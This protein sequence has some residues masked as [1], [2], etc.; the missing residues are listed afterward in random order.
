MSATRIACI[1]LRSGWGNLA[2]M[3]GIRFFR[4]AEA[5]ARRGYEVD[6][7]VDRKHDRITQPKL[8]GP[9]LREVPF[10][11]VRWDDYDV[12]KTFFHA[13]FE[14]L[15]A[16][17]GGDHPFIVS[18]LGSVVGHE[19]TEG[20]YFFGSRRE[21]LF[22]TQ[23][24]IAKRSRVVTVLTNRSAALWW[25]EHGYRTRVWQVPTGVD[26]E[27][28]RIGQNPYLAMGISEPVAIYAGNIYNAADQPEVN[29]L[30]QNRLNRIG[31]LLR[32]D[33]IRLVVVGAG[34][35]DQLDHDVVRHVGPVEG[36]KFWDWQRYARVGLVLAQGP[37]QDNESSKIYYYLRTGLQVVCERPVPNAWL[38]ETTAMGAIVDYDDVEGLAESAARLASSPPRVEG[39]GESMVLHHSWDVRARLYDAL[40]AEARTL[41]NSR[42]RPNQEP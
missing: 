21:R 5:L 19:E 27:I 25:K 2:S 40:F 36:A 33:G 10:Q 26:A 34:D 15:L 22:D 18:K 32:R 1:Y 30:W 8:F 29:R 14:S 12:V 17:G 35:S 11:C 13:G 37:V 16:M 20:V 28:P 4:M 38:L 24:E 23:R 39:V 6:V 3:D 41:R 42:T 9:R 31:A 7:T